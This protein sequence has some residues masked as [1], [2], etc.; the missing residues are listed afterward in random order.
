LPIPVSLQSPADRDRASPRGEDPPTPPHIRITYTAIRLS[1]PDKRLA[2]SAQ[3]GFQVRLRR[4]VK[5]PIRTWPERD[6]APYSPLSFTFPTRGWHR[7]GL[8]WWLYGLAYLLLHLSAWSASLALPDNPSTMPSADC[9]YAIG[10]PYG[11]LSSLRNTHRLSRGNPRQLSSRNRRNL[12]LTP[13]MTSKD[14]RLRCILVPSV[15]RL[16][17]RF[18]V[19]SAHDFASGSSPR[20]I[21]EPQ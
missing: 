4:S 1:R 20:S 7:S 19:R 14:F 21:T 5:L 3:S 16:I 10:F 9:R 15:H 12:R 2:T 8:Q 18:S 13:H 11:S 6:D 17:S